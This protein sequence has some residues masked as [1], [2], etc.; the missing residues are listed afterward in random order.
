MFDGLRNYAEKTRGHWHWHSSSLAA[1]SGS[2]PKVAPSHRDMH[3]AQPPIGIDSKIQVRMHPALVHPGHAS[4]SRAT[5]R[6][7]PRTS[8]SGMNAKVGDNP[9]AHLRRAD[10]IHAP[11]SS[12]KLVKERDAVSAARELH[13]EAARWIKDPSPEEQARINNFNAK[14]LSKRRR[15]W[16][17]RDDRVGFID[18]HHT[19]EDYKATLRSSRTSRETREFVRESLV[20]HRL[21]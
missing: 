12:A 6:P 5:S 17:R 4:S 15:R 2:V 8:F 16:R 19:L 18:E 10:G 11:G 1:A 9:S 7:A 3:S 20:F 21:I 14:P 13:R